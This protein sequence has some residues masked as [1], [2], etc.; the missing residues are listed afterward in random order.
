MVDR[1]KGQLPQALARL[2]SR[3][4]QWEATVYVHEPEEANP[5][6]AYTANLKHTFDD[7]LRVEISHKRSDG[8]WFANIDIK[9]HH[10]KSAYDY[11]TVFWGQY[12]SNSSDD[13][14]RLLA[15][16]IYQATKALALE[17]SESIRKARDSFFGR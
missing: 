4:P 1:P 10:G 7:G 9:Q 8:R 6:L 16:F 3:R 13:G 15:N 17:R 12:M 2:T 11:D 14:Y 5:P